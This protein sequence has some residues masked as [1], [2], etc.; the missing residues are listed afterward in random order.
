MKKRVIAITTTRDMTTIRVKNHR[1]S[2]IVPVKP[3]K[4]DTMY[5]KL[6]FSNI[7]PRVLLLMIIFN[8]KYHHKSLIHI[9]I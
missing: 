4:V 8:Q 6:N 2:K 7:K 5:Y 3:L 1:R 9:V